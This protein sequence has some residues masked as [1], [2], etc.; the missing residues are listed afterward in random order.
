M[1]AVPRLR[2]NHAVFYATLTLFCAWLLVGPP[3]GVW[4]WVYEW[5]VLSFIRVPSRFVIVGPLGLGVL[6]ALGFG[7]EFLRVV[8]LSNVHTVIPGRVYRTAQ[9]SPDRLQKFI[10]D[11]GLRTVINLRGVCG[12]MPWYLGECRATHA[13]NVNQEDITFSAKRFPAPAEV[14]P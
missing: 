4:Q 11:K 14:R 7:A 9:L 6:A 1:R 13:A 3:Y 12:D 10:A 5:P 8:A 2:T